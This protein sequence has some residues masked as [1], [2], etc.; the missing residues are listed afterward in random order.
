M[1]GVQLLTAAGHA[2]YGDRWQTPIAWDTGTTDGTVRNWLFNPHA[3]PV[4]L[5]S[6][7]EAVLERIGAVNEESTRQ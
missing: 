4:N 5:R 7:L 2:L 1:T 3:T 6:R